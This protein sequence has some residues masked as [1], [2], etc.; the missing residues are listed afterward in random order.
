MY[1][2]WNSVHVF[3]VVDGIH[4]WFSVPFNM[5]YPVRA[6]VG[7]MYPTCVKP[8]AANFVCSCRLDVLGVRQ[9]SV[10]EQGT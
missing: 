2:T 7:H 5:L 3:A 10:H 8:V 9:L 6:D 4:L 1:P